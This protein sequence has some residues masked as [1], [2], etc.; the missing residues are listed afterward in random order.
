MHK[1]YQY[2]QKYNVRTVD[3]YAKKL[4]LSCRTL[5]NI[6]LSSANMTPK[7]LIDSIII[8]IIKNM[9]FSSNLNNQQIAEKLN[10]SDQSAFGQ[11]FKRNEKISLSAFRKNNGV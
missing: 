8:A 4:N 9:V 10:F 6:T 2:I 11:Y 7:E 1:F 5:Y 3:F